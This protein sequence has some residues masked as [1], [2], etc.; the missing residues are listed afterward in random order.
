MARKIVLKTPLRDLEKIHHTADE[1]LKDLKEILTNIR[2]EGKAALGK[3]LKAAAKV[4]DFL[5]GDLRSHIETEENALFPFLEKHIPKL[6][7]IIRLLCSEHE[8]FRKSLQ[9][10]ECALREL[11]D[12]KSGQE[13]GKSLEKLNEQGTYLIYLLRNH[14]QAEAEGVYKVADRELKLKEKIELTKRM[15]FGNR[16]LLFK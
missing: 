5:N 16:N 9:G 14:I 15:K 8:D 11:S 7:P 1:N 12:E 4:F 6:E 3:N 13:R 10:F 2:Y